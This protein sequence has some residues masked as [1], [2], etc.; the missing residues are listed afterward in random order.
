ML[1]NVSF[2]SFGQAQ[3][4]V[5]RTFGLYGEK[6]ILENNYSIYFVYQDESEKVI[7]KPTIQNDTFYIPKMMLQNRNI[8]YYFLLEYQGKVYYYYLGYVEDPEVIT[9]IDMYIEKKPFRI[10]NPMQVKMGDFIWPKEVIDNP[11]I[12]IVV[13]IVFHG[14]YI[15]Y[16]PIKDIKSY[17]LKGE[18]LLRIGN[19]PN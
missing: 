15:G 3:P 1:M 9:P 2:M 16:E 8:K 14:E 12:Q 17:F 10:V 18:E 5:F 4:F 19:V 7:Y 13:G 11:D 6:Q